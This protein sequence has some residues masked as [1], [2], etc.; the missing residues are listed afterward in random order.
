MTNNFR[1]YRSLFQFRFFDSH[2]H[3][4]EQVRGC[5]ARQGEDRLVRLIQLDWVHHYPADPGLSWQQ[6]PQFC[7]FRGCLLYWS[8]WF[9]LQ[10]LTY[11]L[12]HLSSTTTPA[13]VLIFEMLSRFGQCDNSCCGQI[14]E[15]WEHVIVHY[16][17]N[18]FKLLNTSP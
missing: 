14:P 6:F 9:N 12:Q 1:K 5:C 8:P 17:S 13:V 10:M 2:V 3:L 16:L 11:F 4:P 7:S 18:F 15:W